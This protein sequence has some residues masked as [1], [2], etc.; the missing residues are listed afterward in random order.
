MSG[1]LGELRGTCQVDLHLGVNGCQDSFHQFLDGFTVVAVIGGEF[2]VARGTHARDRKRQE[3]HLVAGQLNP[4]VGQAPDEALGECVGRGARQLPVPG[5]QYPQGAGLAGPVRG[6][7]GPAGQLGNVDGIQP[8]LGVKPGDR[9]L[10]P[11]P[12]R[13]VVIGGGVVVSQDQQALLQLRAAQHQ[14]D[15]GAS[16]DLQFPLADMFPD[17]VE[18]RHHGRA[19]HRHF[20]RQF[21][22]PHGLGGAEQAGDD[23]RG[24]GGGVV[25]GSAG[26]QPGTD[27][28][29]AGRVGHQQAVAALHQ[30]DGGSLAEQF[31]Q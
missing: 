30:G 2:A 17:P 24:S 12:T 21:L 26:G 7:D 25:E 14:T 18:V 15:M 10:D 9:L 20:L 8:G 22:D 6:H 28:P 23:E 19:A 4:V 5:G 3:G 16:L 31:L 11:L 29:V 1:E 13:V 27:G